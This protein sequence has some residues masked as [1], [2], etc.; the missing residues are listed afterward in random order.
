MN[1]TNALRILDKNDVAYEIFEYDRNM[2][3]GVSIAATLNENCASVFKTLV[4]EANTREN[5]VFVV[6]VDKTLDLKKA[7]QISGVKNVAMIKQKQLLPLTGYIHG[8]CCPVGMKKSFRTFIDETAKNQPFFFISAGR[9][10]MQMKVS[11]A[12]IARV[13]NAG[14]AD[15]TLKAGQ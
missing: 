3:D 2:T 12:D 8:G 4:T 1:K 9:T 6:P 10:G 14:F 7:A 5:L 15:L 11:P 13:A